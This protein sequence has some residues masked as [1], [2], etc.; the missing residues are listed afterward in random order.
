M[1]TT[2]TATPHI[3]T[4]TVD[5]AE[6]EV[7]CFGYGLD[8]D[9][10]ELPRVALRTFDRATGEPVVDVSTNLP[11]KPISDGEFFVKDATVRKEVI[12]SLVD[13][14]VIRPTG[15]TVSYGPFSET[16]HVYALVTG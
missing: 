4:V 12:T 14:Q 8:V 5:G 11:G 13:A 3:A 1:R 6:I 7:W 9:P 15:R 2:T 10:C 16:A